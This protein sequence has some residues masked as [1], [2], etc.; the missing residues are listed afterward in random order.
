MNNVKLIYNNSLNVN[1]SPYYTY[2]IKLILADVANHLPLRN[3]PA[4]I[5]ASLAVIA[6]CI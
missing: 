2:A 1:L 5:T 4:P 6:A 3:A